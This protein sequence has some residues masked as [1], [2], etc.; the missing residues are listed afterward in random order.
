MLT[1]V[2]KGAVFWFPTVF[3]LTFSLNLYKISYLVFLVG[4]KQ[5]NF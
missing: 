2:A 5:G 4:L 1:K 3:L